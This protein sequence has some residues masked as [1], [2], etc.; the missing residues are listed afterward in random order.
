MRVFVGFPPLLS[1]QTSSGAVRRCVQPG[2]PPPGL[3]ER[4]SGQRPRE[5]ARLR[6]WRP[7]CPKVFSSQEGSDRPLALRRSN[8]GPAPM[9]SALLPQ[10]LGPPALTL[11]ILQILA[12]TIDNSRVILEIDNSRLAADDFRLK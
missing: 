10:L 8:P 11:C 7:G 2:G 5:V 6:P 3:R 1:R 12:A 9:L 4:P